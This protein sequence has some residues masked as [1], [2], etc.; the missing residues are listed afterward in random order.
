VHSCDIRHAA[1]FP[2]STVIFGH[3]TDEEPGKRLSSVQ[4]GVILTF[5]H[6]S[7]WKKRQCTSFASCRLCWAFH[8]ISN[9]WIGYKYLKGA[10]TYISSNNDSS[11]SHLHCVRQLCVT[12]VIFIPC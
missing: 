11:P 12:Y 1:S 5:A 8:S 3:E 4:D 2:L 9:F 6:A 7:V 10:W